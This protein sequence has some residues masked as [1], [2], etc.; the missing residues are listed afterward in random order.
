M[1]CRFDEKK[2]NLDTKKRKRT[3]YFIEKD[4]NVEKERRNEFF[5]R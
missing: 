2:A 5:L 1:L 3:Q 4:E